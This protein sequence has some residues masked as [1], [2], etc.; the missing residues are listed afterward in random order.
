[1]NMSYHLASGQPA[2]PK[3]VDLNWSGYR[4]LDGLSGTNPSCGCPFD[5]LGTDGSA[6]PKYMFVPQ[7]VQ[8]I[9]PNDPRLVGR[10]LITRTYK[11]PEVPVITDFCAAMGVSVD[12]GKGAFPNNLSGL[13]KAIVDSGRFV[14]VTFDDPIC[15]LTPQSVSGL[16]AIQAQ[17]TMTTPKYTSVM[18][19][20][21]PQVSYKP[22]V[23]QTKI[24]SVVS[25]AGVKTTQ[26]S[27]PTAQIK[28]VVGA[29][30][31]MREGG[32]AA[33]KT[34]RYMGLTPDEFRKTVG[35]KT[36]FT[37]YLP[38]GV[39]STVGFWSQ[40]GLG[41]GQTASASS[42]GLMWAALA[43]LVVGGAYMA[44]R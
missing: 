37:L 39:P 12:D 33:N 25:S 3:Y 18:Q 34:V 21:M 6:G 24:A 22:P 9:P 16:G 36:F 17:I 15:P 43:A 11:Y 5:G 20:S 4:P 23:L 27:L 44:M 19:G 10:G 8:I 32:P 14:V 41:P 2:I 28:P 42:D 26:L 40:L 30:V 1:V 13:V 7:G 38:F 29:N 31:I 35:N